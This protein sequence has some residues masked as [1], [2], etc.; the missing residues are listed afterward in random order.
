[1]TLPR[2][3]ALLCV[4]LAAAMLLPAARAQEEKKDYLTDAEADQIRDARLP[5]DRI[6]LFVQFASDRLKQFQYELAHK[7]TENRRSELLN[8]ILN[9]YAGCVDDATDQLDIAMESQQDIRPALKDFE[10]HAKTFLETLQKI[11]KD[12]QELDTYSDTLDDAIDATHDALTDLAK[13]G[14]QSS[15][16]PVRRKP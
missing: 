12:G 3:S 10:S 9:A 2:L 14:K 11:R 6:P 8:G 7:H 4:A 5:V 15:Q 1:M 13:A 16:P